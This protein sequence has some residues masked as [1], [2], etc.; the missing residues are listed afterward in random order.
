MM[1]TS[2]SLRQLDQTLFSRKRL[3]VYLGISTATL[4]R[5]RGDPMLNFP[6]PV[7]RFLPTQRWRRADID[8]W[9]DAQPTKATA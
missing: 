8:A 3:A 6:K 4:H 1:A 9:I 7:S 2:T 5:W